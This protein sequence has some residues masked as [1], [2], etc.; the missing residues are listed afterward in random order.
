M[1]LYLAGQY[2]ENDG[3]R[4]ANEVKGGASLEIPTLGPWSRSPKLD[5]ERDGLEKLDLRTR[6]TAGAGYSLLNRPNHKLKTRGGA[7]YEHENFVDGETANDL[8]LEIGLEYFLKFGGSIKFTHATTYYPA[9]HDFGNYR[10]VPDTA[11]VIPLTK[12]N[13]LML[14]LGGV[15]N[16]YDLSPTTGAKRLDTSYHTNILW[17]LK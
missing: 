13:D 14:K 1:K 10:V 5:L 7:G 15:R 11:L 9:F 8:V 16:Q 6:V 12:T 4:S 2:G 3:E 17:K